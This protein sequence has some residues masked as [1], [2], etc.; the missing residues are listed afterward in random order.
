LEEIVPYP[1]KAKSALHEKC[2]EGLGE[3]LAENM[4]YNFF[5]GDNVVFS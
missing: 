2:L 5:E 1:V 3:V 4:A